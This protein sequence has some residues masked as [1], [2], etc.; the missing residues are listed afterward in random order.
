MKEYETGDTV[1]VKAKVDRAPSGSG[2]LYRL[3]TEKGTVVW[4]APEELAGEPGQ[5][6]EKK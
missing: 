6:G 1:Y 2:R 5:A 3:I 4:A